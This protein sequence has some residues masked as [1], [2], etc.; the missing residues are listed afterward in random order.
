MRPDLDSLYRE[1]AKRLAVLAFQLTGDHA[2]AEDVV[3]ETFVAAH[4]GISAFRGEAEPSTW[5]YRIAL[6][7]SARL[8][9]K[10]RRQRGSVLRE[11]DAQ[12]RGGSGDDVEEM[13]RALDALSEKHRV[14]LSLM[15][16][17][18][19]SV[20]HVAAVLGIPEGTVWSRASM[21]RKR[22]RALM[23][24]REAVGGG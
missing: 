6:R 19:L 24:E 5:L 10:A 4:K 12:A 23:R 16:L 22:M 20:A 17:R 8:R 14:V 7:V 9:E 21:A 18:E 11:E 1:N 15:N 3:Q 13:L 2:L